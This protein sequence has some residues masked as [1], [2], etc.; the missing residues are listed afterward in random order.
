EQRAVA[1]LADAASVEAEAAAGAGVLVPGVSRWLGRVNA[2]V[3][4]SSADCE[5]AAQAVLSMAT[6][7]SAALSGTYAVTNPEEDIWPGDVLSV[8]SSDVTHSLLVRGVEVKDQ[9]AAPEVLTYLIHFAND[10]AAE[11]A[12]G[13]GLKLSAGIAS[14]AV[15]PANPESAP[16][17]ALA[18]LPSLTVTSLSSTEIVVDAGCTPPPGGGFEVKRKDWVFGPGVDTPD[19]VLRSPVRS[20][21]IPRAAQVE[22]YF[23]RM[24]DG[25]TPARYSRFSSGLFVNWPVG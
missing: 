22:E 18:N 17:S 5:S 14:D 20:F 1:R 7:R 13:M 25:S 19:L 15:L 23:I 24:Y 3:A 16:A 11:W 21:S 4:R 2:P 8:T 9:H 10:W 6:A 12:D